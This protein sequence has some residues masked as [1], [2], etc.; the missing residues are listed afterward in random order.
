VDTQTRHALKQDSFVEATASGLGWLSE[1]RSLMVKTAI[2]LVITAVVIVAAVLLYT[3]R[4]AKADDLFGQ[5]MSI[6]GTAL[7]QPGQPV[8]PGEASYQTAAERAKAAN[9]LFVQVASDYGW[10]R[11]GTNARYFVGLTEED[12]GQTSAAEND[13]KKAAGSMDKGVAALAKVALAS[14]YHQ[15]GRD[16]Q[17]ISTLQELVKNPTV[18][19]PA[20]A[21]K[22][23]LAAIYE[24]TQPQ[25]A[26]R[27][28][29][30][31]KDQDK[32]TAAGQI[33]AQKLQTLK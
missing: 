5:A 1:H 4:E 9:P 17:A 23:Q 31:I 30:E 11:V 26:K 19:V 24:K 32:D 15:T 3:S 25:E 12:M 20:F 14:L 2:T 29:A 27:L 13:L 10:F 33:A 22:L 18:T 7:R 21:A 28:Y 16:P 8:S 6:Y